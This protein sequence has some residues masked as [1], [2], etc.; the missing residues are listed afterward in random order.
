[1]PGFITHLMFGELAL[2]EIDN[3]KTKALLKQNK[4]AFGLGLEGPDI[5][6]YHI[7][8][9]IFHKRNIGNIIHDTSVSVF[10]DNLLNARNR[11][12]DISAQ[13]VADAYICGFL[14][15]YT[16]DVA[17]HPYIFCRT[18][19]FAAIERRGKSFDFGN[20]I[21]LETDIDHVLLAHFKH[22]KPTE[23]DY[24]ASVKPSAFDLDVI[25]SLLEYAI[26]KT[27]KDEHIQ[28]S[29]IKGAISSFVTLNKMMHD[30]TGI[31]KK[32]VR[33]LEQI[34]F[35]HAVISSMVPSDRL[36]KFKDPLNLKHREW[37][38]EWDSS[39]KSTESILEL[40][41][42]HTEKFIDR[43]TLYKKV[44]SPSYEAEKG[45]AIYYK[46]ILLDELGNNS[47]SSGLPLEE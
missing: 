1:M 16:L 15:H 8:S 20:H 14:G 43:I 39:I 2:G 22:L 46:A 41:N 23:Y 26:N 4:T 44:F 29:S 45:D 12:T 19:H 38:N 32:G 6:F 30:P 18:N 10:F 21:S 3:Q 36:I 13:Q 5:F 34:F 17:C 35:G 7:P 24:A 47:Y 9:H 27:F 37:A 25:A 28:K 40:M 42:S 11:I 33:A 31:K